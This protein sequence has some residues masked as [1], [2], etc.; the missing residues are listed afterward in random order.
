MDG[1]ESYNLGKGL[2][3]MAL[4]K[5]ALEE[6]NNSTNS[7]ASH[8]LLGGVMDMVDEVLKEMAEAFARM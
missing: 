4:I 3:Q 8:Y 6:Y 2:G 5:T 1:D 7:P